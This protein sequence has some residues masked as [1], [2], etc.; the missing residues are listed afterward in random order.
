M[1]VVGTA[2]VAV[3]D[4]RLVVL[5][6]VRVVKK[7][8]ARKGEDLTGWVPLLALLVRKRADVLPVPVAPN[9]C[10][11]ALDVVCMFLVV[12][13]VYSILLGKAEAVEDRVSL[14]VLADFV[15]CCRCC[16]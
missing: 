3:G 16:G 6:T 12:N 11:N 1:S 15:C 10:R 9:L 13:S 2:V 14:I 5:P 8:A 7:R 4:C